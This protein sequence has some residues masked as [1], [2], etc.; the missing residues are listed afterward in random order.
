MREVYISGEKY[1]STRDFVLAQGLGK[2]ARSSWNKQM[3]TIKRKVPTRRGLQTL[4]F[5]KETDLIAQAQRMTN[6]QKHG[7]VYCFV[8]IGDS[9]VIKIGRTVDWKKRWYIGF[10]KPR[11]LICIEPTPD[12]RKSEALLKSYLISHSDFLQR[13]DLGDEWFQTSLTPEEVKKIVQP[14]MTIPV[15]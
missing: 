13:L 8:P 10:N 4:T 3:D 11:L 14:I 5:A 15:V 12:M 7:V 1:I 6:K 2:C 9:H